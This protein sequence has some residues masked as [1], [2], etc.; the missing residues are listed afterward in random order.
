MKETELGRPVSI[1]EVFIRTHTRPDGSFVDPKSQN[2]AEAYEKNLED[3]MSQLM[4]DTSDC[5][6]ELTTAAKDD[7]F[8]KTTD[9]DDRGN[10]FGLGSLRRQY[11]K[12]K[13]K[14]G[15][16]TS[17]V[18]VFS[19]L[20]EQLQ[21]AQRKIEVQAA[22]IAAREVESAEQLN[23][24]GNLEMVLSYLK[25]TD[26]KFTDY[27]TQQSTPAATHSPGGTP[28]PEVTPTPEGMVSGGEPI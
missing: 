4:D 22:A 15:P 2:I 13:R 10:E 17:A 25:S 21:A 14:G 12:G 3:S 9:T 27:V 11:G 1:G 23:R 5:S 8:L 18:S 20:Q 19:G 16:G 7:V 26:P 28:T 24:I 6:S